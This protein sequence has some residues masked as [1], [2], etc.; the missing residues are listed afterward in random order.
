MYI[1][2]RPPMDPTRDEG[3]D[4]SSIRPYKD[5]DLDSLVAIEQACFPNAW[6]RR[7]L[8]DWIQR[9]DS[10]CRV[11]EQEDRIVGFL[12]I[13]DEPGG[14]H[15]IN[16]AIDPAYRRRSLALSALEWVD[17]LAGER[18]VKQ[19]V[20]EVRETNLAA[21][22]LYRKAGYRAVGIV[23]DYYSGDDAYRMVKRFGD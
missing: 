17:E 16:L 18:T 5:D 13:V 9:A 19:V 20:L 14:L 11:L 22:L 21:Q 1:P 8:V 10:D 3:D 6:S 15:L 23:S 4:V 12:L 7:V 2:C